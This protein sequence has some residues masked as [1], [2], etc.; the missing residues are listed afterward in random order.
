MNFH[1][2]IDTDQD[3]WR[4]SVGF[5]G[6][7]N[8]GKSSIVNTLRKKKVCKTA[9]IAGETKV[10]QYVMLMRRIYMIDCPGVVYPQGD[11][12][13]QIILKGVLRDPVLLLLCN[14]YAAFF[15]LTLGTTRSRIARR[16]RESLSYFSLSCDDMRNKSK[17]MNK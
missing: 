12:E 1:R 17:Q 9:P 10:W 3:L 6:Y 8:V 11:S 13:T 7:P 15:T 5:I 2:G 14:L 16:C 4:I